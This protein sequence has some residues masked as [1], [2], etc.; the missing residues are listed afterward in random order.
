MKVTVT[1]SS[2]PVPVSEREKRVLEPGF[3]KYFT[4]HMVRA[5]WNQASGW[6]DASVEAYGP[7]SLDPAAMVFHY[8]QE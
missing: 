8:G 6:S 7:F 4:D 1:P 5:E 2:N 3:G